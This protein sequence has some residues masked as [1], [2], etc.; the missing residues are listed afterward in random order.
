MK[1]G[2]RRLLRGAKLIAKHVFGSD[3]AWRSIATLESELPI[4]RLGG[5]LAAYADALD[6]AM[7]AKQDAAC[8]RIVENRS[9]GP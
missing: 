5:R 9:T 2:Q 1:A 8:E 4:F 7:R 3:D 6:E